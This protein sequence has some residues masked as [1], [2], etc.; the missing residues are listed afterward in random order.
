MLARLPHFGKLSALLALA[1][2]Q[3]LWLAGCASTPP[4]QAS[5][6]VHHTQSYTKLKTDFANTKAVRKKL[7]REYSQ[8]KQTPYRYGGQSKK[9]IDCSAFV[10]TTFKQQ[11]GLILPRT[12]KQQVKAGRYVPMSKLKPGDVVF[13]NI[14]LGVF[15]SGH[16]NGIYLGNHHFMHASSSEGV[17]ISSLKNDF[18]R[19]HYWTAR[20]IGT[21]LTQNP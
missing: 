14:G 17:T 16:H 21:S 4:K 9:G 3:P 6:P 1:V 5:Y 20:R 11:F 10:Q 18:W 19:R 12:T 8:W 13:F 15:D 2:L 7:L